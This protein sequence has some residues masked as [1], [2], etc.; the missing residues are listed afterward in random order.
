[1]PELTGPPEPTDA[2]LWRFVDGEL[3]PA[4]AAA[5][6]RA[7]SARGAVADRIVEMRAIN[8]AVLEDAPRPPVGF[9]ARVAATARLRGGPAPAEMLE[10]RLFV[11]RVLIAATVVAAVG[12][13]YMAIDVVPDLVERLV[14][15]PDPL[16]ERR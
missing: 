2:Q 8:T 13:A 5:I 16:M 11:R 1:M 14:A 4:E 12:I 15:E 3:A 10:M 9:A 7:A 6:E